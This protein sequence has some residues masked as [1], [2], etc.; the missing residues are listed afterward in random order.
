[1][2][3]SAPSTEHRVGSR[4]SQL[5][6]IQTD[7][8]I[9]ELGRL[10]RPGHTFTVVQMSTLGDNVLDKALSKI[11]EKSLF[12]KELEVALEAGE[13]DFVVHSM[14]DLPT[15]LPPGLVIGAV[16]E[17]QDPRDA[18]V[19]R[20]GSSAEGLGE[21]EAGAVIGTSSLRRTAQLRAAYPHLQFQDV[22]GNLNTRL[23]KLD[24]PSGPYSA[25]ILAAAGIQR[26]GWQERIS[27]FLGPETCMHAVGRGSGAV[28]CSAVQVGQGALAVECRASDRAT[29]QLLAQLHHR[30][31]VLQVASSLPTRAPGCTALQ[32]TALQTIAERAFMKMLE[33][34]CSV[35]VAA[36]CKVPPLEGGGRLPGAG[37]RA[38]AE[39][40]RLVPRRR[41]QGGGRA[42][43]HSSTC[44]QKLFCVWHRHRHDM[45]VTQTHTVGIDL[46]VTF[47]C[48]DD[49]GKDSA[50][51]PDKRLCPT[52]T[53]NF[54]AVFAQ[55]LPLSEL[56]AAERCG[57]TLAKDLIARWGRQCTGPGTDLQ[58]RRPHPEGGQAR[59]DPHQPAAER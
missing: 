30:E 44:S 16:L 51:P 52:S 36:T 27:E 5:A 15:T 39:G 23:Q 13:V 29:L 28:K 37:G 53:V 25:L 31:T 57:V 55:L 46:Q 6:L 38:P 19:L 9:S 33:G 43:G 18:V 48:T 12:T 41:D 42:P 49:L 32:S 24:D 22:R 2:P 40:R 14:K 26:M 34:G 56:A 20:A 54:A 8:V 10:A 35:P 11:G 3:A 7:F 47:A 59:R 21:L 45:A 58:G 4:K 50:L 17:R 1:M